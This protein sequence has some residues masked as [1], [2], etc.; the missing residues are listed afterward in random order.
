MSGEAS[1]L[2][3]ELDGGQREAVVD[4]VRAGVGDCVLVSHGT[5]ARL[6]VGDP[7]ST[8]DAAITAI[9]DDIDVHTVS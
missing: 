5:A 1:L 3:V 6:A 4:T 9:V 7:N 2:L 8:V